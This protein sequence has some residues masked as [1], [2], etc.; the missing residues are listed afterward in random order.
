MD[1]E[2]RRPEDALPPDAD[3][4]FHSVSDELQ[5]IKMKYEAEMMRVLDD[6]KRTKEVR[7]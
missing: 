2:A 3:A 5:E 6:Q 1:H 7:R 4:V